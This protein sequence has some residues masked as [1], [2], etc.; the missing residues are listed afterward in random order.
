[1]ETWK[2]I[3]GYEG[4]YKVS[5][6]GN[7][8]NAY[9]KPMSPSVNGQGYRT[10]R[11]SKNNKAKTFQVSVLVAMAFLQHTP[12]GQTIVVDHIN[13]IKTDDRLKNLQLLTSGENVSKSKK[14]KTSRYVGV[15]WDKNAEKWL[16][17]IMINGKSLHLGHFDI[18][19]EA[20]YA[21][22]KALNKKLG[23]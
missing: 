7:I 17:R 15:C 21:Y 3:P 5:N 18:E 14:N 11:L 16:S 22:L 23:L 10:V 2:D 9:N 13:E 6:K 12:K 19:V 8:R 4:F 1:M 20:F